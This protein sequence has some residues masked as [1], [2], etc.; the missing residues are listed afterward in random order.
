MKKKKEEKKNNNKKKQPGISFSLFF[1]QGWGRWWRSP[2]S[3]GWI[4]GDDVFGPVRN[5]KS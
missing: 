1:F 3:I 2:L 5:N 4:R